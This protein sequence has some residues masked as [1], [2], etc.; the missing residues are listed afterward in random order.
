MYVCM[1]AHE[2]S[3]P[4]R[5]EEKGVG[6]PEAGII[7]SCELSDV[8]AGVVLESSATAAQALNY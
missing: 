1:Y 8:D 5:P 6:S 3:C 4:Q 2:Y 7:G